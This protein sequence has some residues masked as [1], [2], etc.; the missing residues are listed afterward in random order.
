MITKVVLGVALVLIEF[1]ASTLS[2][3]NSLSLS[4]HNDTS[5][6]AKFSSIPEV[7][8]TRSYD[9]TPTLSADF[10]LPENCSAYK[11]SFIFRANARPGKKVCQ[12][13]HVAMRMGMNNV[14]SFFIVKAN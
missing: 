14:L 7:T 6:T 10:R 12:V 3:N 1:S 13:R 8:T 2:Q 9:T 11:V 5:T 4:L